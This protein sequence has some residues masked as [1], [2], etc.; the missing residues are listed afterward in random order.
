MSKINTPKIE[1]R[2]T[3]GRVELRAK[4]DNP[5]EPKNRIRGYAAVFNQ[6]SENLGNNNTYD[7]REVLSPDAFND[8]LNDD[9]RALFNHDPNLLLARSKAGTG[10]LSLGIDETGLWYEF[11]APD[12]QYARD[13]LVSLQR[14]D[15][16]QSSFGFTVNKDG[17]TWE[18]TER[19][20]VSYIKRTITRVSR[21]YDVS[22]VTYPAYPDTTVALRSLEEFQKAAAPAEPVAELSPIPSLW[23]ARLGI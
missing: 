19:D 1:R 3:A 2:F 6:E 14:G 4:S 17:E 8:V 16:D 9:V 13:L 22:P 18:E 5:D 23:A 10:T 21:L 11:D 20:G 15:V 7:F 12:T